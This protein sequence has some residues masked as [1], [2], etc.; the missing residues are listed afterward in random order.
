M[1]YL[2][3]IE[4]GTESIYIMQTTQTREEMLNIENERG[5]KGV[6]RRA[7]AESERQLKVYWEFHGGTGEATGYAEEK[8]I[9]YL[10]L[11]TESGSQLFRLQIAGEM[12]FS[13]LATGLLIDLLFSY[14]K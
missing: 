7:G 2:T 14:F 4:F 5:L 12:I 1:L 11:P 13:C 8:E 10:L 6:E 9:H 3:V